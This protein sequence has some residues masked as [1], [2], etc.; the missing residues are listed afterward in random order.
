[1]KV[2]DVD[3]LCTSVT[4]AVLYTCEACGT[5][6]RAVTVRERR[7]ESDVVDWVQYVAVACGNDHKQRCSYCK[8][9]R[10]TELKIPMPDGSYIG[11]ARRQ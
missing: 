11:K 10:L 2:I 4:L 3:A 1:M 5:L 7:P 9:E 8:A 6:D